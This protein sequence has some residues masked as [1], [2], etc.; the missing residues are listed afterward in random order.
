M[1][2]LRDI[3]KTYQTGRIAVPA[4][5]DLSCGIEEGEI[6]AIM[7]PSGC[8]K[9]TLLNIIGCLDTP[10][11][12]SYTLDGAEV[13]NLSDSQLADIRNKKIGFVFQSFNLLARTSALDNVELPL[14]YGNGGNSRKRA[15]ESLE[16]VGMAHRAAHN[17]SELSGG[18]RQRVAIARALVNRPPII[19]ADEPT[20]N[21]DSRSSE[22]IISIL[23]ELNREDG[24]TVVIVTHEKDIADQTRR[25]VYL[26][27]G[28]IVR[29]QLMPH[30]GVGDSAF[31][32]GGS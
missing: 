30:P 8:G 15:L 18:E 32:N 1:I 14:L 24:I 7:G 17:P 5:Q 27:D 10:T 4:L 23:R 6:V 29:E 21:L 22:D 9:S 19:L 13:S 2:E 20:G 31:S 28:Q 26:K 12:G 11:S 3:V 16:K 25:I